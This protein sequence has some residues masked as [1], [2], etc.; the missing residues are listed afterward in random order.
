MSTL[1]LVG[2]LRLEWRGKPLQ[3]DLHSGE[4]GEAVLCLY[5]LGGMPFPRP[6]KE[7]VPDGTPQPFFF[8]PADPMLALNHLGGWVQEH[9]EAKVRRIVE[10]PVVIGRE[11]PVPNSAERLAELDAEQLDAMLSVP[12]DL[13]RTTHA[14][15]RAACR[16]LRDIEDAEWDASRPWRNVIERA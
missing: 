11:A 3:L 1:P 12:E 6:M 14:E 10:A 2:S 15:V 9:T 5:R 13:L 7:I 8:V 4:C 16:R